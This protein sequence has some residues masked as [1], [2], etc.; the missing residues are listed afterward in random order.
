MIHWPA[1]Q[2]LEFPTYYVRLVNHIYI[3]FR[4]DILL[5][6]VKHILTYMPSI[7]LLSLET[8]G[9]NTKQKQSLRD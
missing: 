3:F 2:I 4:S 7:I 5:F 8:S 6:V 9:E 1:A